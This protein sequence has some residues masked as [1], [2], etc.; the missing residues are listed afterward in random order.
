MNDKTVTEFTE[1]QIA[2][3][4]AVQSTVIMYTTKIHTF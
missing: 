2:G 4:V 1:L 3:T